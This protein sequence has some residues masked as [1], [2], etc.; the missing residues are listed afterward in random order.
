MKKKILLIT[1]FVNP[2]EDSSSR[3]YKLTKILNEYNIEVNLVT[4][5]FDHSKKKK[6]NIDKPFDGVIHL[7]VPTYKKNLSFIRFFSHTVFAFKL[8]LFL[9]KNIKKYDYIYVTVPTSLSALFSIIISKLFKKKVLVDIIDLWPE[10]FVALLPFKNVIKILL[11]PWYLT[12]FTVYKFADELFAESKK[13]KNY[14][15]S[16]SNKKVTYVNLGVDNELIKKNILKSNIKYKKDRNKLYICYGGSLGNSYDFDVIFKAINKINVKYP[17]QIKLL[18]IGGGEKEEII[19]EN[20]RKFNIDGFI[21]GKVSYMDYLKYMSFC[22]IGINTF[23]TST[24]VAY[25]YKFNDYIGS[26][27][28]ICNNLKGETWDIIEQYNLGFNFNNYDE[29]LYDAIDFFMNNK[30]K[31]REIKINSIN[32]S[33]NVANYKHE[34][35]KY[36]NKLEEK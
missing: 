15:E 27:L 3:I 22:D 20:I 28:I 35:K 26:G 1:P 4:T 5:N 29:S 10:S 6:F 14:A 2:Y 36:I 31:I 33:E 18:F 24:K 7:N 25:S 12:S 30:E 32:F 9:I 13:Y 19:R 34:Y 21:T 16:I 23:K 11:S 8:L 17:S